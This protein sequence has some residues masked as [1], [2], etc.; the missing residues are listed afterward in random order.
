M[1]LGATW[2][3]RD[4]STQTFHNVDKPVQGVEVVEG[5]WKFDFPFLADKMVWEQTVNAFVEEHPELKVTYIYTGPSELN[6]KKKTHL[7]LYVFTEPSRD[8]HKSAACCR[9]KLAMLVVR[10][11]SGQVSPPCGGGAFFWEVDWSS[12]QAWLGA[13]FCQK[14]VLLLIPALRLRAGLVD[15][16]GWLMGFEPTTLGT[17]NRC[18][19]Q[20]SY[21]HHVLSKQT[22][23]GLEGSAKIFKLSQSHPLPLCDFFATFDPWQK[24]WKVLHVASW[25][26][27]QGE[28]HRSLG[29]FVAR[30]VEAITKVC[31]TEVWA[32]IPVKGAASAVT[33]MRAANGVENM[34]NERGSWTIRR[35]LYPPN[36]AT[37]PQLVGVARA[38]AGQAASRIMETRCRALARGLSCGIS[39]GCLG[40]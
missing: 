4:F 5:M 29:N 38:M 11:R 10:T 26:P 30:H 19:N 20:L 8:I 21:S 35:F 18:S 40:P 37:R 28:V 9:N 7:L 16:R 23:V 39:G 6:S 22:A 3:I 31:E 25:F 12:N 27:S 36:E 2:S 15:E 1:T 24:S 32:P 14:K 33:K 17:T 34:T 13:E